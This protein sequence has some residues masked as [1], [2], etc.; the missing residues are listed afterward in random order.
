MRR[1]TIALTVAALGLTAAPSW[2]LLAS[3]FRPWPRRVL[4]AR[5]VVAVGRSSY[6]LYLVHMPVLLA[7]ALALE[8]PLGWP[9]GVTLFVVVLALSQILATAGW[10]W[11]ERPSIA[12]GNA[13]WALTGRPRR[14]G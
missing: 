9:A 1:S 5:P 14:R 10:R 13:V 7:C 12:A 6:S 2:A 3:L 11:I 8:G 4:G